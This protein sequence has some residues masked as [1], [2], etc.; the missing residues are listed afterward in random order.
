LLEKLWPDNFVYLALTLTGTNPIIGS[1]D[2]LHLGMG[3]K[4]E[5]LFF[6]HSLGCITKNENSQATKKREEFL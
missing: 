6:I 1:S 3:E 4:F 5:K 2:V